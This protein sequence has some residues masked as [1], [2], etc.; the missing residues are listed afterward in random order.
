MLEQAKRRIHSQ[1]H[2]QFHQVD[3]RAFR[4][5][6]HYDAIVT[7]FFLDCF[8]EPTVEAIVEQLGARL[9]PG[10]LWLYTDFVEDPRRLSNRAWL[11][12]L[13]SAFGLLTDIES[14]KL[15]DP[16]AAFTRIGL[17]LDSARGV[18][19][20]LLVSELWRKTQR[21]VP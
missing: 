17:S 4:P 11:W 3:V 12:T 8:E 19:N 9:L 18:A 21:F 16:R 20:E 13:Y 2:V 10:G 5:T 14:R 6:R 1:Q 15:A 7:C